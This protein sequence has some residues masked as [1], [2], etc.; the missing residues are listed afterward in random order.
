[1]IHKLGLF[2]NGSPE[3]KYGMENFDALWDGGKI[4][5]DAVCNYQKDIP[6]SMRRR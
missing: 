1:M 5:I 3:G 2:T 6:P 4:M